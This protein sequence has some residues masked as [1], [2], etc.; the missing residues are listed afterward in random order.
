VVILIG[1]RAGTAY[2]DFTLA[3]LRRLGIRGNHLKHT[4]QKLAVCATQHMQK[5]GQHR[6]KLQQ[7]AH[8]QQTQ[9]LAL[10]SSLCRIYYGFMD[11][12]DM[13]GGERTTCAS[14]ASSLNLRRANARRPLTHSLTHCLAC[15]SVGWVKPVSTWQVE[16]GWPDI[17]WLARDQ[18]GLVAAVFE[19][20]RSRCK[21]AVGA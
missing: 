4:A 16:L 14:T 13:V 6:Q 15:C 7:G 2:E 1:V 9:E 17:H 21:F 5:I 10:D 8:P 19:F 20:G 12:E 18:G 3:P 11:Q